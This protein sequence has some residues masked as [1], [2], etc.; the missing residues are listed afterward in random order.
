VTTSALI[1]AIK[2]AEDK[3][4]LESLVADMPEIVID[5]RKGLATLKTEVLALLQ[6]EVITEELTYT[7]VTPEMPE[8]LS[9]LP[10]ID[11]EPEVD[12]VKEYVPSNRLIRNTQTG[13][14]VI[15]TAVLSKL[16]NFEEI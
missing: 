15:W 7:N 13:A 3:N 8:N 4:S 1:E 10:D 14:V 12:Q 11:N 5:K 2:S 16:S 6:G 9:Q